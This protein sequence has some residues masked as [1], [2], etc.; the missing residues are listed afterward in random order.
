ME[1]GT[2]LQ[3]MSLD[4]DHKFTCLPF[5]S[6]SGEAVC[7]VIIFQ[8]KTGEVP[9]DWRMGIDASV[10]PIQNGKGKITISHNMGTGKFHPGGPTLMQ[11]NC[12]QGVKVDQFLLSLSTDTRAN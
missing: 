6:A 12:S 5:T 9:L 1:K 3:V 7:C 10:N 2:V 11:L 8:S 4:S